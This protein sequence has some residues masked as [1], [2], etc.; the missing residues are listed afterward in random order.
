M[1]DTENLDESVRVKALKDL[2]KSLSEEEKQTLLINLSMGKK[3]SNAEIF[4]NVRSLIHE[5]LIIF[6]GKQSLFFKR[7]GKQC[8]LKTD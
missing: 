8:W 2:I 1:T 5:H 4:M 7:T 6:D 3:G